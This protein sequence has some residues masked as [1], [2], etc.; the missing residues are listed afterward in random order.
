MKIIVLGSGIVGLASAYFLNKLGHEVT[1]IDRAPKAASETSFANAGQLSFGYTTPW[2]SP[3]TPA[4]VMKWWFKSHSPLLIRPDKSLFQLKWLAKM[5]ANCHH[6]AYMRNQSR[7][8]RI[9]EY[10]RAQF[11]TFAEE[12]NLDFEQRQLGTLHLFRDPK[13]FAAHQ[14]EMGVL[15][16]YDVPYQI[17]SPEACLEYEPNLAHMTDKIAG[18]VRLPHDCT[19]DCH[20]FATQLAKLCEER[21]VK[22]Q[23]NCEISHFDVSG[24]R[25]KA[26]YAN[27]RCYEAEQFL[28]ALGSFSRTMLL[29]LGLDLPIYP[30]KGYSLTIPITDEHKAPQSTI[31]DDTYK[32]AITRFA[33]RIRVGGMAE[34]SGY[35]L[36]LPD[37]HRETLSKVVNEL[38]PDSGDVA[39]ATYWS[40]LRPVTPDSTPIIG[41]TRLEN[42]FT[43]TGH[44]TLGWTMSLG[45]GKII[46]DLMTYDRSEVCAED[47]GMARYGR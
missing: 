15:D 22:F 3:S 34:L 29:Q 21:G 42:L 16:A 8:M 36:S 12:E 7:M 33:Q 46:A 27:G 5:T 4:R 28:C 26:V 31:L 6:S 37:V 32:V 25:V 39:Q 47:L 2:A 10:S 35:E 18:A 38:F 20:L 11:Q 45:S 13:A 19:G 17:L 41:R 30:V 23:F 14:E 43:N 40:G 24:S 9:S 44:G 1:V